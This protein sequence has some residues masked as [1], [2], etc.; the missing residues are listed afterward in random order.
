MRAL[1][2][3]NQKFHRVSTRRVTAPDVLWRGGDRA[4]R[5]YR[6]TR[7]LFHSG[8]AFFRKCVA[9]RPVKHIAVKIDWHKRENSRTTPGGS[10]QRRFTACRTFAFSTAIQATF[11]SRKSKSR[12]ACPLC[13]STRRRRGAEGGRERR[14]KGA[15]LRLLIARQGGASWEGCDRPT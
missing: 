5:P 1:A 14:E 3:S 9:T 7:G 13:L 15:A 12:L 8:S 11:M 10:T 2:K 4:H 6:F